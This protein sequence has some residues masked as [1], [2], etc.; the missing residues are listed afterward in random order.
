MILCSEGGETSSR[1]QTNKTFPAKQTTMSFIMINISQLPKS[2]ARF[3]LCRDQRL[4]LLNVDC[5]TW[6]W[7]GD[8]RGKASYRSCFKAYSN[9]LILLTRSFFRFSWPFLS[10]WR[11]AIRACNTDDTAP[12]NPLSFQLFTHSK[13][14]GSWSH[15]PCLKVP[16]RWS[17]KRLCVGLWHHNKWTLETRECWLTWDG[18]RVSAHGSQTSWWAVEWV[19]PAHSERANKMEMGIF[20]CLLH[21]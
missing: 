6:M 4:S 9:I 14:C 1:Q 7:I 18:M 8:V 19:R 17:L 20:T 10:P 3:I 15:Q 16:Q 5:E 13:Q 21:T 11:K 2:D 12:L